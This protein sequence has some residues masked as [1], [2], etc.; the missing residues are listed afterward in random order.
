MTSYVKDWLVSRRTDKR[1]RLSFLKFQLQSEAANLVAEMAQL[2]QESRR[3]QDQ[4]GG[5]ALATVSHLLSEA[6]TAP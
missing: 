1:Q 6:D 5:Q 4:K 3:L 2:E